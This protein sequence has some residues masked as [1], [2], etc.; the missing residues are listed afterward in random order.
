MILPAFRLH[1]P[2]SIDEALIVAASCDNDFDYVGGGTDLLPNYK[3]RLNPRRNVIALWRVP[4][5]HAMNGGSLG[6]MMR[7]VE[8]ERD[9]D[10][11]RRWPGLIEAVEQVAT[12]LVRQQATL[13]GNLLVETR[14]YYFNQSHDWRAS[15][16]YCMKADGDV[17][18]VVPQKEV[19]Y[20]VYSGDAAAVLLALDATFTIHGFEGE[21]EVRARDFFQPDGIRRNVLRRGDILTSVRLPPEAESYRAGYLKLRLRDSYDFPDAGVAAAVK[22]DGGIVEDLQVVVNAV[23]MT[24]LIYSDITGPARGERL[25]PALIQDLAAAIAARIQPVRNVMFPPQ[26]RKRMV[27]VL[28][29]RLLTRLTLPAR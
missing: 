10:V 7:L 29:R 11:Q 3:N 6:A 2:T 26:Y 25:T 28:A 1:R 24:P 12:P 5:L 15:K 23:S 18:L 16:G 17:C 4:D 21:R 14:C 20:A 8:L 9:P 27:G 19:C 22:L 13:G